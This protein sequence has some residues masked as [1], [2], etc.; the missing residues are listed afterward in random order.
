MSN[1]PVQKSTTSIPVQNYVPAVAGS[2]FGWTREAG[3][4]QKSRRKNRMKTTLI[5][6]AA[7]VIG[8]L[9]LHAQDKP[10]IVVRPFTFAPSVA[11]PYDM[12]QMQ[13]Q[14]A[15]QL[16]TKA[17]GRFEVVTEVPTTSHRR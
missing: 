12:K 5:L 14:T 10:V 9:S 6:V 7:L 4:F 8:S 11:W 16:K 3:G 2:F 15:A 13:T 1:I 17:G